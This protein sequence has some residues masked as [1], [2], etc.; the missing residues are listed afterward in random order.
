MPRPRPAQAS[1]FRPS[2]SANV[3]AP[4]CVRACAAGRNMRAAHQRGTWTEMAKYL[5]ARLDCHSGNVRPSQPVEGAKTKLSRSG[6][7]APQRLLDAL[8]AWR[9]ETMYADDDGFVF[10]SRE[11][12]RRAAPRRVTTTRGLCSSGCDSCGCHQGR[13]RRDLRPRWRSC[14]AVRLPQPRAAFSGDVPHDEQENPAVVQAIMRHAKM[15]MTLCYSHS[16]RKAKR[17]AQ[18]K[19]LQHLLPGEGIRVRMR[20]PETM[21]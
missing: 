20:Q 12:T 8:A 3:D 13:G 19:V 18:E 16:R 21:Q 2:Q 15:D 1:R 11:A 10:P 4:T 5:M 7:E 14:G 9:R 6:V 17:A